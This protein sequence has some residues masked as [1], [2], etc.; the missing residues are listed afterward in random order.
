[1][2]EK[3]GAIVIIINRVIELNNI[4]WVTPKFDV[5]GLFGSKFNRSIME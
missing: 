3:R 1:M 4:E 5:D 2:G